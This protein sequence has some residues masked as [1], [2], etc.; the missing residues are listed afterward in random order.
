[1]NDW[2]SRTL[3]IRICIL[4][5]GKKYRWIKALAELKGNRMEGSS[6][7][8]LPLIPAI[9]VKTAAAMPILL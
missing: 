3:E 9:E 2:G 1:M 8:Q 7:Y 6:D 5:L 4:P